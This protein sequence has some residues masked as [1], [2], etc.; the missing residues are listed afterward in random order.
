MFTVV[1]PRKNRAECQLGVK[2]LPTSTTVGWKNPLHLIFKTDV[3]DIA[4]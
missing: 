2:L 1:S 3:I 4:Y